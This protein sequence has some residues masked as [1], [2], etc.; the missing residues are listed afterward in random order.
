VRTKFVSESNSGAVLVTSGNVK[1]HSLN[2]GGANT[3][4]MWMSENSEEILRLHSRALKEH[5]I[6]IV[7][8]THTS[9]NCGLAFMQS[10]SA[11]VE[12]GLTASAQNAMTI[13]P[14]ARWGVATKGSE[15]ELYDD[16][17]GRVVFMSGIYFTK[18]RMPFSDKIKSTDRQEKQDIL[19]GGSNDLPRV[20]EKGPSGSD[21]DLA[22]TFFPPTTSVDRDA[23]AEGQFPLFDTA[24]PK[25]TSTPNS[26][27]ARSTRQTTRQATLKSLEKQTAGIKRK[28]TGNADGEEQK[29]SSKRK[30]S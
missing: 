17:R 2:N 8:R 15:T 7:T 5:G 13:S 28:Q 25:T 18:S 4:L 12:I 30:R 29:P 24:A 3:A 21:V 11:S 19:R 26:T 9:T 16:N 23:I 1:S 10:K 22:W 20:I 27:E 14:A 6:W